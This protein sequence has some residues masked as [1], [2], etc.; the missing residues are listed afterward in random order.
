M[1]STAD[2]LSLPEAAVVAN[3]SLRDLNRVIDEDLL[4]RELYRKSDGRRLRIEACP[5]VAFYFTAANELT[6]ETRSTVIHLAWDRLPKPPSRSN[7]AFR[8]V[9]K[10]MKPA[11]RQF[12]L[13][14]ITI[15]LS[16]FFESTANR[17]VDLA[18]AKAMVVEDE[19]VLGGT[20]VVRGTR[21]PVHDVAASLARGLPG[22]RIRQAYPQLDDRQ[23][24][25][26]A[27]Y[28]KAFPVRGR[29]PSSKGHGARLVSEKKIARRR[30]A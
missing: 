12:R 22:D 28:A 1:T 2:L 21:I 18:A 9:I 23:I 3:V 29:P 8:S 24:E 15:D 11:D 7:E 6:S 13:N 27:I 17:L 19:E 25:L 4:P 14:F 10:A 5:L 26:A 30:R 20:P 16:T